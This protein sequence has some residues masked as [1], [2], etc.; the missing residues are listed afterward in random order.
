MRELASRLEQHLPESRHDRE[1]LAWS[2]GVSLTTIEEML[3]GERNAMML[4]LYLVCHARQAPL[5]ALFGEVEATLQGRAPL[6]I[7]RD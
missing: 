2:A 7:A 6:A 3:Q 5:S 1:R 4:T